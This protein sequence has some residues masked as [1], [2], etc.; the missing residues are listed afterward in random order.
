M[1][2]RGGAV[3]TSRK[4]ARLQSSASC[5]GPARLIALSRAR[6]TATSA[7]A[8][9]SAAPRNM[10]WRVA[11]RLPGKRHVTWDRIDADHPDRRAGQQER[12]TQAPCTAA[13]IKDML[14]TLNPGKSD[15][16][17]RKAGTPAAHEE[18][19]GGGIGVAHALFPLEANK[20]FWNRQLL[21]A[22]LTLTRFRR[23]A[24]PPSIQEARPAACGP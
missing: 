1:A 8:S 23:G 5:W 13:D 20:R 22:A 3:L 10:D 19:V 21:S 17:P 6:R 11:D 9:A 24:P 4:P 14:R 15:E 2:S 18:L 16:R 7:G 12:G